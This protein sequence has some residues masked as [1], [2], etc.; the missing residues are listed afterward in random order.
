MAFYAVSS[1]FLTCKTPGQQVDG[2]A[3]VMIESMKKVGFADDGTGAG[4]VIDVAAS[5]RDLNVIGPPNGYDPDAGKTW[6]LVKEEFKELAEEH[7]PDVNITTVGRKLLG[8]FLGKDEGLVT[9]VEKQIAKWSEDIN[10]LIEIAKFEPQLAYAAYI[11][12]TSKR[13][14]FLCR[15][16]PGIG[17]LLKPLEDLID[18]KL[19]PAL[20]GEHNYSQHLRGVFA[21][22]ARLGGLGLLIPH[23]EAQF[24]YEN[25]LIMTE[26]LT[27]AIV[28]QQDSFAED[29]V[30]QAEAAKE[31]TKRKA[32]KYEA[33]LAEATVGFPADL[34]KM[35]D[36]AKE[37]GASCWL[38]SL[39]LKSCGFRLSKQQWFDAIT[40][41]YNL[42]P[43]DFPVFCACGK[44]NSIDH[45][46]TC[47][48]GGFVHLRHDAVRDSF[49]EIMRSV[50]KDVKTEPHL[51]PV[52][53]EPLPAGTNIKDGAQADV[54]A[55]SIWT[56][57]CKAFF[58]IRVFNPLA[59]TNWEMDIVDMYKHH[60]DAKKNT[61]GKENVYSIDFLLH[62]WSW[63]RIRKADETSGQP[64]L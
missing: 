16:T 55:L 37:K 2:G 34:V 42:K 22:P 24:E 63:Q 7:L 11:F 36:L 13:W 64:Y 56:S 35:L 58:D 51:L 1:K 54:S 18:E 41:R 38:T 61:G 44:E 10:E 40:M 59:S 17:S 46:L 21:L 29:K 19:I 14:Q 57:L 23:K 25:S 27:R 48:K 43:N 9:H 5:W 4:R 28:N 6:V 32:A 33:D 53:G 8:S 62:W 45:C 26:Q 31:I 50:G 47:K 3:N 12:G 30:K 52:T 39:P 49:A 20:V 15:T 60:E